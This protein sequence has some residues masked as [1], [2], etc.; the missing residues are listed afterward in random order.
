MWQYDNRMM[1]ILDKDEIETRECFPTVCPVCGKKEAHIYAHRFKE[2][3]D[4]GGE[5]AWCS[6]CRNC[7]HV[8]VRLP[9]WWKNSD[10]IDFNKLSSIPDYLEDNKICIDAWINN[11]LFAEF[12]GK[13][14]SKAE[15]FD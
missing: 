15:I 2:G 12:T 1:D 11:L 6:A 7:V 14:R 3:E 8:S 4:R 10:L 5:W 9:K 13:V